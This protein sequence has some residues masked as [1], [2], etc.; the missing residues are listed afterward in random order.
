MT[1]R[2]H[3]ILLSEIKSIE[4]PHISKAYIARMKKHYKNL[5]EYDLLLTVEKDPNDDFFYF[6]VN[7]TNRKE[8]PC[9]IEKDSATIGNRNLKLL[10][11]R[12]FNRGDTGTENKQTLLNRLSVNIKL[13]EIVRKTGFKASKIRN[14][15]E[16]HE[17]VD[18]EL[19]TNHTAIKTA[20][21]IIGLK[22]KKETETFLLERAGLPQR[23]PQ[24]LTY[25]SKKIAFDLIV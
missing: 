10:L 9:I 5:D 12:L 13:A 6:L 7:Y 11:S 22:L 18:S 4:N 3:N 19:I 2:I 17:D 14:E 21:W 8:A 24:R 1:T 23:N 20:N 25:E 15:Y 16:F